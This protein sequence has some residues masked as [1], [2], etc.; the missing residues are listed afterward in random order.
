MVVSYF[1]DT[2]QA[3]QIKADDILRALIKQLLL[4]RQE[5]DD[6]L[7]AEFLAKLH[8]LFSS[9]TT[10]VPHSS[11]LITLAKELC[12]GNL[13]TYFVLDGI[14]GLTEDA[15]IRLLG[16]MKELTASIEANQSARRILIFCR[17]S[18]GRGIRFENDPRFSSFQIALKHVESD[19]HAFV[20]HE[21]TSKQDERSL[22]QSRDLL[23]EVVNVLKSNSAKM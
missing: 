15:I 1:V 9:T 10:L 12:N 3:H 8:T 5:T 21:V 19:I 11:Q 2:L 4:A 7:E 23:D 18:L 13:K 6:T 14:D 20:D 16:M 22:I 17:E